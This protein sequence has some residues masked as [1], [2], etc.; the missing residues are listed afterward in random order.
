MKTS[1]KKYVTIFLLQAHIYNCPQWKEPNGDAIV[2]IDEV[3]ICIKVL[4][5]API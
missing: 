5:S 4:T 1:H 2:C 3:F